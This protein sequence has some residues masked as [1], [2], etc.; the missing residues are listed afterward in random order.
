[1]QIRLKIMSSRYKKRI[2][3]IITI[4]TLLFGVAYLPGRFL[5]LDEKP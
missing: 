5:V 4:M 1:M 3:L 2:I